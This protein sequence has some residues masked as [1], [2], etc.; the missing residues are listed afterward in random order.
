MR[1]VLFLGK[2]EGLRRHPKGISYG[3]SIFRC[4]TKDRGERQTK[5]LLPKFFLFPDLSIF[6]EKY[7]TS[8]P[9]FDKLFV[10]DVLQ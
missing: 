4:T 1:Y 6:F 3:H 5:K 2:S 8:L 10:R 9:D 7:L